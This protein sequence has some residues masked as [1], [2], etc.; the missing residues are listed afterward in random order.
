MIALFIMTT[1]RSR[2]MRPRPEAALALLGALWLAVPAGSILAMPLAPPAPPVPSTGAPHPTAPVVKVAGMTLEI[3]SGRVVVTQVAKGSPADLAGVLPLDILLVVNDRSLVDLDPI[4]PQQ[5]L[6]LLPREPTLR[7][8]L[9]LG[10]GAGTLS[11]D[12]PQDLSGTW[13]VP[14]T[15]EEVRPGAQAPLFTGRDLQGKETALKD[16]LG[17]P[18][19]LDFW[20]STCPPCEGAAIPLR[21]IAEKYEGNLVVVGI[22]LD[23]DRKAFEAFVYNQHLPGV[24]LLDGGGWKGPIVRLYGVPANGIPYYVLLDAAGRVAALGDLAGVERAIERLTATPR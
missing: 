10:R 21:R 18:V 9:V 23:E 12:L 22:S 6:G 16:L 1:A 19:L 7:T 20:A 13:A 24:Q 2:R 5:V 3:R 17:K 15:T 11:I 4:T 14:A 8:R